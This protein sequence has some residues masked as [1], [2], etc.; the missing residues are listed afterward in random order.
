MPFEEVD[1]EEFLTDEEREAFEGLD[2]EVSDD[3][4]DPEP[5]EDP[6]QE[7]PESEEE[8][9]K[10]D[11]PEP[12]PEEPE[13]EDDPEPEKDDDPEPEPEEPAKE[14][15]PEP[16]VKHRYKSSDEYDKDLQ[17]Q[18]DQLKTDRDDGKLDLDEYLDKRDR[19]VREQ[20]D[21]DYE[22]NESQRTALKIESEFFK[23]N[24]D[25]RPEKNSIRFNVMN[26]QVK[27]LQDD[28]E[29]SNKPY[30]ELLDEAKFRAEEAFG[31]PRSKD[32]K[33][34]NKG[35]PGDDKQKR[36]KQNKKP[37]ESV[38]DLPSEDDVEVSGG[39]FAELDAMDP[40][41]LEDALARM[42]TDRR[43]AYLAR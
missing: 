31:I 1:H 33:Q 4:D 12:E 15:D 20:G 13:K 40:I 2:D 16:E 35:G 8:P 5:E 7:E 43:E 19:V 36:P 14:D 22:R 3:L 25:Y 24:P 6:D 21:R 32:Q 17:E 41:E 29:W 18:L 30:R 42:S 26:D 9:E 27:E 28:P 38:A 11:D 34:E 10:D 23:A 39:E 37:P